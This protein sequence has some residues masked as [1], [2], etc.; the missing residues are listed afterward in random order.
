MIEVITQKTIWQTGNTKG[1][2]DIYGF[3]VMI[4]GYDQF[5]KGVTEKPLQLN[6]RKSHYILHHAVIN[7]GKKQFYDW[8]CVWC[9]C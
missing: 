7:P 3:W 8:N 6:N 1:H 5:K 4:K 9:I 2:D